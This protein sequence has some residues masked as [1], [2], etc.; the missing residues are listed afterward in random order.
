MNFPVLPRDNAEPAKLATPLPPLYIGPWLIDPPILQAPMA[1]F[2][3]YVYRQIVREYGGAGLL[4]TEM[5][6][7]TGFSYLTGGLKGAVE[8]LWGVAAEPKPLAAQIWDKNAATLAETGRRL[9][10]EYKV[11]IVDLNF[12][13]PVRKVVER[14]ESG[15]YLLNTPAKVGA[16]IARVAKACA[17][18]PVTAKIRLGCTHAKMTAR[19]VV[20]VIEESGG[21]A[22]TVHGRV[23]EDFFS[24]QAD[25]ERI[26]ELKTVLKK[27]PLI[28]NGDLNSAAMVVK[29]F[30]QYA[31]AGVMIGRSGLGR[32]WLFRQAA[33]ALQGLAPKPEPGL[34]E[35]RELLLRHHRLITAHFGEERGNLLMRKFS[36]CYAQGRPGARQFRA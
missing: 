23:A 24:G 10:N 25:W 36:C 11:S 27:I 26:A 5:I 13:C 3:N 6:S 31:P 9:V 4:T 21:A 12:G 34:A 14:A 29:A 8:R 32:P 16:I 18:A 35:Q 20:R 30:N 15:S 7:A 22:V 19:E 17:P 1:G 33:D 28:G 2:S